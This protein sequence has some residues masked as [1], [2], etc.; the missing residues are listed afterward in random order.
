MEIEKLE[1]RL[2]EE[3]LVLKAATQSLVILIRIVFLTEKSFL[4]KSNE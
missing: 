4:M 2:S 3:E 1:A